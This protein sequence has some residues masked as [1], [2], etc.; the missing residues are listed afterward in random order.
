M[1]W[2]KLLFR[3]NLSDEARGTSAFICKILHLFDALIEEKN[4]A[5]LILAKSRSMEWGHVYNIKCIWVFQPDFECTILRVAQKQKKT[6][7]KQSLI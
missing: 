1:T 3:T 4:S 2:S 6:G 7:H 5:D